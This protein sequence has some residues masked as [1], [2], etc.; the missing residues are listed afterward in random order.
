VS[1]PATLTLE[2]ADRFDRLRRISWWNQDKLRDAKVAVIG[3]ARQ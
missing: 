3:C 2:D 1:E